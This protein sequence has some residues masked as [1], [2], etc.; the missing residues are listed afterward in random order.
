MAKK[1]KQ[2]APNVAMSPVRFLKER[3]A[4]LPIYKCY[5][6][7][8]WKQGGEAMVVVS[9]ERGNGNLCVAFFLVDVFCLGVKDAFGEVNY[10]KENLQ[11]YIDR[12]TFFKETDYP[13]V[14]NIVYGA[15]EFAEESGIEP[16]KEFETWGNVLSEDNDDIPLI[17]IEF[18][19]NGKHLLVTEAGSKESL[20]IPSLRKKLGDNFDYL[21]SDADSDELEDY[22]ELE[23]PYSYEWPEYPEKLSVKYWFVADALFSKENFESLPRKTVDRILALPK[24]EAAADLSAIMIEEIKNTYALIRDNENVKISDSSIFQALLLLTLIG[25]PSGL[26]AILELMRQSEDFLD[27]HIGDAAAEF[28]T[29]ALVACGKERIHDLENFLNE[30]GRILG[31]KESA[32]TALVTIAHFHPEMREEII[33]IFR[34]LLEAMPERLRK[35]EAADPI[36]AAFIISDLADLKAK[37]LIPEIKTVMETGLVEETVCGNFDDVCADINN[38]TT[39]NDFK[40][41]YDNDELLDLLINE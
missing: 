16:C 38:D 36:S 3:A 1:K 2:S 32:S 27:H 33:G 6:N 19:K 30:P 37:E 39:H 17:D 22:G 41:Y 35:R 4:S 18:G 31:A 26:D 28:L 10:T 9:R 24:E 7:E 34:R 14:H 40:P 11:A 29:P 12:N 8:T 20:L 5:I 21:I 13:L 15:I 25:S 23:E